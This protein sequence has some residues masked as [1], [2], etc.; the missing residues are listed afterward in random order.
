MIED[1]VVSRPYVTVHVTSLPLPP[2]MNLVTTFHVYCYT[3]L[4]NVALLLHFKHSLPLSVSL[5]MSN[6]VCASPKLQKLVESYCRNKKDKFVM[7]HS[8]MAVRYKHYLLLLLIII[9]GKFWR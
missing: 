4:Q 7:D 3:L 1:Y 6:V 8:V 2:C 9:I 5:S